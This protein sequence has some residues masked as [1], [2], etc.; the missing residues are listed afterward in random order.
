MGACLFALSS[1]PW[2]GFACLPRQARIPPTQTKRCSA[3][4]LAENYI[5]LFPFVRLLPSWAAVLLSVSA[6]PPLDRFTRFSEILVRFFLGSEPRAEVVLVCGEILPSA[7]ARLRQ[8]REAKR[9]RLRVLRERAVLRS[10]PARTSLPSPPPWCRWCSSYRRGPKT[11]PLASSEKASSLQEEEE[12]AALAMKRRVFSAFFAFLWERSSSSRWPAPSPLSHDSR[13]G[14]G[15]G[16]LLSL[17]W[18][19]HLLEPGQRLGP[20]VQR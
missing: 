19:K 15:R 17:I 3:A 13:A 20:D 1:Q 18:K 12:H 5:P 7:A 11:W 10:S 8:E 9:R 2:G 4:L 14:R 16:V 6:R